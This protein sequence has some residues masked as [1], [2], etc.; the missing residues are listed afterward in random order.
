MLMG[1]VLAIFLILA[2][3]LSMLGSSPKSDGEYRIDT[4]A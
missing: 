1:A 4:E 3:F 2:L